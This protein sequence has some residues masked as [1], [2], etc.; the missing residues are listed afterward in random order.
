MDTTSPQELMNRMLTG[1][2]TSQAVYVAAKLGIADLLTH[3]PRSANDLA[4]T[5]KAHAPSLYRLLRG[6]ASLEVFAEDG[7]GRFSLTPLG[8]CLR[9]DAPGSQRALAD[10]VRGRALP[11]MGRAAVQRADRKGRF[12]EV[13]RHAGV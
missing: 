11:G 13:V 5:T 12:R 8:E 4:Q 10:H 2:W 9:S 7:A 1:Y 3:G 6:L